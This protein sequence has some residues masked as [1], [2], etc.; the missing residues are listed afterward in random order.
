MSLPRQLA[1]ASKPAP[2]KDALPAFA[3]GGVQGSSRTVPL[4]N[5]LKGNEGSK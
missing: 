1:P 5:L 4:A 2:K 3:Q